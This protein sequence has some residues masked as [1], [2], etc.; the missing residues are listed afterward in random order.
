MPGRGYFLIEVL[1]KNRFVPAAVFN[2]HCC[3][4][5]VYDI[6]LGNLNRVMEAMAY[7][8]QSPSG[9]GLRYRRKHIV[10]IQNLCSQAA[11]P[12]QD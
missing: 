5:L 10:V 12:G 6:P 11:P 1:I 3:I 7:P 4:A 2:K 9:L 8:A